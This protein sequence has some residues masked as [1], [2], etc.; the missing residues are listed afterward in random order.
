MKLN[1]KKIG[2][3]IALVL[4]A[5]VCGALLYPSMPDKVPSHWNAAGE[6]DGQ[7]SKKL[8]LF[9]LP[10]IALAM[11]G[12]FIVIPK[13]DPLKKNIELFK[14]HYENMMVLLVGFMIYIYALTLAW[15]L[16]Y[17]FPINYAMAIAMAALFYYLGI[18]IGKAKRNWFVGIKTPWTLSSD[19]VWNKTHELGGKLFKVLAI[20]FP[21]SIAF[22]QI[23]IGIA[24]LL[25][26]TL[27]LLAYSFWIYQTAQ[28]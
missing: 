10:G 22:N 8:G 23:F 28:H 25:G 1:R 20:V 15:S 12:L 21:A 3:A 19:D 14:E 27:F 2:I 24:A 18:V 17:K 13:I 7:I 4:L 9:M 11:I 16:G 6:V 26:T 5:F